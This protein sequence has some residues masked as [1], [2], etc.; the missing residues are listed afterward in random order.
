MARRIDRHR[1]RERRERM[2]TAM[3]AQTMAPKSGVERADVLNDVLA[4]ECRKAGL[5][6][7]TFERDPPED[8]AERSPIPLKASPAFPR[9]TSAE[10]G[11]RSSRAEYNLEFAGRLYV[12]PRWTIDPPPDTPE[13]RAVQQKFIFLG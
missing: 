9:T 8:A 7:N 2:A 13:L 5:P 6:A 1:K 3:K 4:E 11:H 12:S 10:I